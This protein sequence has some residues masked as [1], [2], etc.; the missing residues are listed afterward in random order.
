MAKDDSEAGVGLKPTGDE[1]GTQLQQ[2]VSQERGEGEGGGNGDTEGE[3]VG[4]RMVSQGSGRVT[5][6]VKLRTGEW[7]PMGVGRV[8]LWGWSEWR[9]W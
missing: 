2:E 9:D 4:R 1:R 8:T 6:E 7:Y 5:P 3:A